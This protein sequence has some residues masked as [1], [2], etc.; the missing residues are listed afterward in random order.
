LILQIII[1]IY[2]AIYLSGKTYTPTT[3]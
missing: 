1:I 3:G 2:K